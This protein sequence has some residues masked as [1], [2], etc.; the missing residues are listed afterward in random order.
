MK[1][2]I[3]I[4]TMFLALVFGGIFII[5]NVNANGDESHNASADTYQEKLMS[6]EEIELSQPAEFLTIDGN[7]NKN[8][9]G[10]KIKIRGVI[11]NTATVT[12][13]KDIVVKVSYYTKTETEIGN[14]EYIIYDRFPPNSQIDFE[15]KIRNYE[16]VNTVKCDIIQAEGY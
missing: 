8:F 10:D 13:Y 2:N 16:N 15:L 7:Y 1:K 6:I 12:S 14:K 11:N 4:V 5:R 3:L 9:W